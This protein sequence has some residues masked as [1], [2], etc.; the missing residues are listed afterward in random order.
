MT[1]M[2]TC[3]EAANGINI[4]SPR[5]KISY[6]HLLKPNP[7][8]KSKGRDGETL[9]KYTL[10]ILIPPD[11]DISLLKR[12]AEAAGVEEW[13][14]EKFKALAGMA[15]DGKFNIPFLDAFAKSKTVK[16]PAGDDWMKGWGMIRLSS[17]N[18]PQIINALN[19]PVDD[20][21]EIYPG[22]WARVSVFAKAYPSIDGGNPGVNF[23]LV[24]VQLLDHDT[25]LAGSAVRAEDEF[26]PVEGVADTT[27]GGD[28]SES[29]GSTDSVF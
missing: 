10:T 1:D 25:P 23:R 5:V 29:S 22:R 27:G 9:L 12:Q 20:A 24:N 21:S 7:K 8:A 2:K 11:C 19:N 18:Q 16:K 26:E 4:L 15:S 14:V 6:P 13:G 28:D 17:F 3:K